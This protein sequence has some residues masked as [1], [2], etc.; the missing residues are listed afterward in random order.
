MLLKKLQKKGNNKRGSNKDNKSDKKGKNVHK[1]GEKMNKKKRGKN[2]KKGQQKC[3]KK[4]CQKLR[5]EKN[6]TK[7][8]RKK[9]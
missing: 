8:G 6:A 1:K 7:K 2:T 3:H 5:W 9:W 4:N